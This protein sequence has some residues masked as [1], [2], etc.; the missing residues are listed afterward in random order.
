MKFKISLVTEKIVI[1]ELNKINE[2]ATRIEVLNNESLY[3]AFKR[4]PF[5]G[6]PHKMRRF[7]KWLNE[8]IVMKC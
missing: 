2:L 1:Q 5:F 4:K 3:S 7:L 6:K 8:P